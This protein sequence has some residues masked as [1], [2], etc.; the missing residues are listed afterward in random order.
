MVLNYVNVV[1]GEKN[2]KFMMRQ[3]WQT[4]FAFECYLF[5]WLKKTRDELVLIFPKA[6]T[7]ADETWTFF[8]T[9]TALKN[10]N[11]A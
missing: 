8:Y 2:M 6:H 10:K 4:N 7:F 5:L 1:P 11:V 9:L 3:Y